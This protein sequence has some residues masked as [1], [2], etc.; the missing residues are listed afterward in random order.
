MKIKMKGGITVND[1]FAEIKGLFRIQNT[2]SIGQH[3]SFNIFIF[4]GIE[5]IE[6][7]LF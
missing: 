4:Q 1:F 6:D 3:E 5:K 7:I 2:Q